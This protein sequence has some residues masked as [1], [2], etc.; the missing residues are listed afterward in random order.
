[1]SELEFRLS[2]PPIVEA[3]LD[4]ECD[5]PPGQSLGSL[6]AKARERYRDRYPKPVIQFFQEHQLGAGPGTKPRLSF[7]RGIQALRFLQEDEKQLVQVRVQGFSF[8]RLAP[9]TSLDEYLAR[10]RLSRGT[11]VIFDARGQL[12]RSAP[13]LSEATTPRGRRAAVLRL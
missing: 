6:Q 1:M 10:L 11:L 2:K 13:R 7:R 5:M 12:A 8:N 3:I 9:Y 4:L